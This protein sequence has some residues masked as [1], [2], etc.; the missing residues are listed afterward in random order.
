[1]VVEQDYDADVTVLSE[2]IGQVSETGD[3]RSG[4][5]LPLGA[6]EWGGGTNFA[7]FSR[8]AS[9]VWLEFFER[10]ED[11]DPSRVIALDPVHHRTGDIWHVW[12]AGV[13]PGQLYGYRA[14][15][16]YAPHKGH[17]YNKHK[18]LVDPFASAVAYRSDWEFGPARGYDAASP[19]EDLS[20]S[21]L[22]DAGAMPKCVV[23]HNHFDWEDVRS[24]RRAWSETV[25]YETH[26]RGFTIHESSGV[27]HPGT[28][29]GLTEKIPYLTDLG[30]TAVELMPVFEFNEN[31][32]TR[33]N[34]LT[35]ERLKNYWG[36]NPVAFTAPESLY[37][38]HGTEGQQRIEFKEMVK[39]FHRA[40]IEV[41]LDVVLNHT[42][43]GDRLGPTFG[44]RGLDN[45]IYYMLDGDDQRFY[46]N[47]SGTGNTLNANHPVVRGIILDILRYWVIDM[48]VDGFRFD[49]ASV[50]GRDVHGNLLPNPP[51]LESIAED[52]ILRNVKIIAEA[53]D[54][55]GAYQVGSF[56]KRR[57]AEWNGRYRD[58]VRRYWRGDEG[59]LGAFASRICGSADLYQGSGKGPESSVNFV[60]CHDG[61][62]L[63]DLVSYERK[64]NEANGEDN[65]DGIDENFS[66]NYGVEGETKRAEIEALRCRQIK[67][68]LATLLVSKGVP[69]LL[70]G[71]EFRRTQRGNNNAYCQDND[72]SWYD[73]YKLLEHRH[74]HRFVHAMVGFR[75]AHPVLG[76][77]S[78][79]TEEQ[80]K[81]FGPGAGA[82][83]W[84]DPGQ[85]CL[86][87]MVLDDER[88]D[89]FLAFNASTEPVQF[90][91]PARDDG[92][93][94]YR[95][96]DTAAACPEDFAENEGRLLE[97]QAVCPVADRSVVILLAHD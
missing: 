82:P 92:E 42:A 50:L 72:I 96:V 63:N 53:W 25:I 43:E 79:Y 24:P 37:C 54:V 47:Y 80:I 31:E 38:S 19:D 83:D 74:L 78:F 27:A 69:M 68:F 84:L 62:T 81:W 36:Y 55:G 88:G 97:D 59:M 11:V 48:R 3:I 60:T 39:A 7:L 45:R 44:F 73:W 87:C 85:K 10:P 13:A 71:D 65:Q 28:Y 93:Q 40:R 8:H 33:S 6:N 61:F 30:I 90:A 34:P 2:Y 41:I 35:G 15:G 32:L 1:M 9:H 52:P 51:L 18:L 75:R 58:D 76:R 66:R 21:E 64:H 23:A 89:V 86:A 5:P 16:L 94:W 49:L 67:N 57:W 77:P 56:S 17:R 12:V 95:V 14:D 22:D 46:R 70:G 29:R 20:F 26:V 4:S 91:L